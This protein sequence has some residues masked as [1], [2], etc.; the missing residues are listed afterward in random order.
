MRTGCAVSPQR[1]IGVRP[2]EG[3]RGAST[4]EAAPQCCS[5]GLLPWA[6]VGE[7]SLSPEPPHQY[8]Y[9]L[10]VPKPKIFGTGGEFR[11]LYPKYG[12]K[13]DRDGYISAARRCEVSQAFTKDWSCSPV[14]LLSCHQPPNKKL[15]SNTHCAL[16]TSLF[17]QHRF[18]TLTP[19][20]LP[21]IRFSH[22]TL[23]SP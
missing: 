14:F 12:H 7:H 23:N 17:Y 9:G 22:W 4:T 20:C 10:T 11:W 6:W 19:L 8:W 15:S 13:G 2:A 18:T 5:M 16:K 3:H 1:G 21:Q